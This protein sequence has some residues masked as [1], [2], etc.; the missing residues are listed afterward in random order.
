M[1]ISVEDQQSGGKNLLQ[2]ARGLQCMEVAYR[3]P[4]LHPGLLPQGRPAQ[5]THPAPADLQLVGPGLGP[6]L[7]EDQ[8]QLGEESQGGDFMNGMRV[9][10][11]SEH[12]QEQSV[13]GS[14]LRPGGAVG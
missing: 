5:W 9:G 6:A 3:K 2:W 1:Q 11:G 12:S 7:L 13:P 4:Q 14:G 10:V 8:S